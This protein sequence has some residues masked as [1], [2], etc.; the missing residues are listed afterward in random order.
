MLK[1][2]VLSQKNADRNRKCIK[3]AE[4]EKKTKK[5]RIS[6]RKRFK[7]KT[8]TSNNNLKSIN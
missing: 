2:I 4:I 5:K 3:T 6:K 7:Q 8:K 1:H